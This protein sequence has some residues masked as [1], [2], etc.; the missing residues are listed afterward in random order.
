MTSNQSRGFVSAIVVAAGASTR[1]GAN[2]MLLMLGA[3]TVFERA[4]R[5]FE[6]SAEVDEIVV[7]ASEDNLARYRDI[8]KD[9]LISKVTSIV[10]GGS[11]RG[12][13]VR[14]GM[15]CC[16]KNADVIVIHD[17]ARP[18]IKPDSVDETVRLAREHGAA[19]VCVKSK[20]SIKMIDGD[21][22][23]SSV[24]RDKTVLI[25]T[26]QAFKRDIIFRAHD[27]AA[28]AGFE[29]TDDCALTERIGVSARLL[30]LPYVNLKL[31]EPI[32]LALAKA[33]LQERGKL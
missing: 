21:Y 12:E 30:Y 28:A 14:R 1:M 22:A 7:V 10:R 6:D 26:P 11:S 16:A 3:M 2:K 8:V 15:D 29:G 4:V 9:S 31:T 19:S 24:D 18:L 33:V 27:E 32:D 25:Q 5:V 17:G 23:V 13:S 20:D